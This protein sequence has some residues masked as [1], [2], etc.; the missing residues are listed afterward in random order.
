M[1]VKELRK[2][3]K[4]L[5]PGMEVVVLQGE[6]LFS[7]CRGGS[8]IIK[9]VIDDKEQDAFLIAP[10]MCGQEHSINLN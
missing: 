6:E 9:A 3:L 10:C 2:I 4:E 8:Q 7:G 5:P 1:K